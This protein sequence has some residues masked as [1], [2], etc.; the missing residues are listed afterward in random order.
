MQKLDAN[1]TGLVFA[2]LMLA[3]HLCWLVL[4]VLGWAQ[5]L[6]DFI[7]WMHHIQPVFVVRPFNATMA[8]LLLGF[9]AL[10][11]YIAGNLGATVW[12]ILHEV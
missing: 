4:V 1:R 11:G 6:M 7:F 12:N 2:A 9:T 8:G 10:V 3:F 5:P